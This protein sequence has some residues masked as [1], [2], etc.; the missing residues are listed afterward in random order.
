MPAATSTM[1]PRVGPTM[2]L[3]FWFTMS[4]AMACGMRSLRSASEASLHT[5]IG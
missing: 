4:N 3:T 5:S 1:P 2:R